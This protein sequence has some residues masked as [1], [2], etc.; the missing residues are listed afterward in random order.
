M[1]KLKHIN[2]II[3]ITLIDL[4][5]FITE[6]Q[7]MKIT[8]KIL[9]CALSASFLSACGGSGEGNSTTSTSST[10]PAPLQPVVSL[11]VSEGPYVVNTPYTVSWEI[12]N[13]EDCTFSGALTDTVSSSGSTTVTPTQAGT[14]DITLTCG[15]VTDSLSV[16]VLAATVSIPDPVFADALSRAGYEVNGGEMNTDVALSIEMLC[17]TSLVGFY[18]SPDENNTAIFVNNFVADGGVRC[19]YTD[20]Y[21]TDT[22]GLESFTNLRTMRLEHQVIEQIDLS[23]NPNLE[24]LSLWGQPLTDIDL[25][26]NPKI[27][28]LGLS[29]TSLRTVDTSMLPLLDEV[30]FQNSEGLTLPYTLN[31]GTVVY[32][33]EELDFS[34]NIPLNQVYV[35]NNNLNNFSSMGLEE[36]SGSVSEIWA[37]E[38]PVAELD[39]TDFV[40]LNYLVLQ[41][42]ENLNT[43]IL[44]NINSG[45]VPF[46]LVVEN[47]PNLVEIQVD[48]P[49]LYEQARANNEIRV[50]ES[51]AFVQA[52]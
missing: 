51:I 25:S 31:N 8:S 14:N 42:M 39:F 26:G 28:V 12:F 27:N 22:T 33:F 41:N 29:E 9:A 24:F 15:N 11:S 52:L 46:R 38:N 35:I 2:Y 19:A 17:I 48:D 20:D 43:L 18:G 6:I 44:K 7:M 21:I 3:C 32:G 23:G 10:P 36:R 47:A 4:L 50:D 16:D 34:E 30:A 13:A 37:S 49:Q 1:F 45:Q 5:N 40:R